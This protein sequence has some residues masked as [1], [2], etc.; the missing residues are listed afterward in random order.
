MRENNFKLKTIRVISMALIIALMISAFSI[1]ATAAPNAEFDESAVMTD[2]LL[3]LDTADNQVIYDKNSDAVRP[4]ASTVKILTCILALEEIDDI[5][6]TMIEI[7][8]APINDIL[9]QDATTA[10]FENNLG[11]SYSAK[12][13]IYGLML[14]SGCDAAQI[15]AYYIGG[16]P[17]NFAKMLNYKAKELGCKDTVLYEAHGLSDQNR[18]TAK[19]LAKIAQYAMTLPLFNEIVSSE[20]YTAQG[21]SYPYINTNYLIDREN[22]REYYY[23]YATGIKTGYTTQ[24]GKCLVSTATKG[25]HTYM[26][27]ALGGAFSEDD[28]Y[29]NHAM[30]DTVALYKW[31]FDNFTDNIYVDILRSYA[32]VEVSKQLEIYPSTSVQTQLRW[33]SSNENVATVDE[34]GIVTAKSMGQALITAETP[35]GNIDT[36]AVSC[37]FYNGIDVTS[38]YGD[39]SNGTKEPLDWAAIKENG[40]DFAV[41]R[42]GWGSEDYP[43]QNDAEFVTNVKG[44]TEN[45]I[46]FLLSFIAYAQSTDEAVA[47]AE[48]F[49]REMDEYFP[50]ECE[51]SMLSV[52]YNMTYSPY[53]SNDAQLNTDVA[54]TFA[55]ELEEEGYET[56]IFAN[57]S[58]YSNLD[59]EKLTLNGIGTYYSYYPYSPDFSQNIA[60]PDGSVPM[61]WQYRSDGYF[62]QASENLNTKQSIIYMASTFEGEQVKPEVNA[63]LLNNTDIAFS[64]SVTDVPAYSYSIIELGDNNERALVGQP[65]SNTN[66]YVL[67]GATEGNHRYILEKRIRDLV[68]GNWVTISSDEINIQTYLFAD[69]NHDT[70]VDVIDATYIQKVIADLITPEAGFEIYGDVNKDGD[71]NVLDATY[72]QRMLADLI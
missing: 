15:L 9:E 72:I 64:W 49:L 16:T 22:G 58:V 26:C 14:P 71:V 53:S 68:T 61:M 55:K 24:S 19:D 2:S 29:V 59:T 10:G 43:N 31:A 23:P 17:E 38:R 13:I 45:N 52:V 5:E 1:C 27:I 3:L 48:Y 41:I 62:P 57:K 70:K 18:T 56:I 44:A 4:M 69:V 46:P 33:T 54:L 65:D 12:D 7:T 39:Y 35:T 40:F 67:E 11:N 20:Y 28:S 8:Q 30:T 37:G 60:L 34:F 50:Q 63:T 66:E 6:N 47:E 32:S 21:F 51:S 42:A 25:E 36:I